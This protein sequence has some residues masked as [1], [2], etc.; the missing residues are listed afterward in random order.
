ML[1]S[2]KTLVTALVGKTEQRDQFEDNDCRLATAALLIRAATIDDTMSDA[3]RGKLRAVLKSHF[4]LNDTA[5]AELIEKGAEADRKAVDLYHF[6]RR[7]N[8]SLDDEGCRRIVEMMWE[9]IYADGAVSGSGGQYRLA[10]RR[11]ARSFLA[12]THRDCAVVL[13]PG[14]T[15]AGE[16]G[17][18]A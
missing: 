9:I 5:T 12:P 8:A 15:L 17:A 11:S 3:R 16:C 14:R 10:R 7:I 4:G 13:R 18:P 6:T 2:L 1:G